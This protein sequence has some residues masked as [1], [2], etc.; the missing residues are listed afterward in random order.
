[1]NLEHSTY[2]CTYIINEHASVSKEKRDCFGTVAT[3]TQAGR[4]N[5]RHIRKNTR[6][7]TVQ[8]KILQRCRLNPF[9]R[10][11]HPK[12]QLTIYVRES[13][14]NYMDSSLKDFLYF[15]L[16]NCLHFSFNCSRISQSWLPKHDRESQNMI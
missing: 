8:V 5:Q 2:Y 9:E 4:Y 10:L 11:Y 6:G 7:I 15:W 13:C 14:Y 1:M 16:P 3:E 12:L